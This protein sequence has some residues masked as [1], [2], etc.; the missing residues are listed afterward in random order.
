MI[1]MADGST[2]PIEQVEAGDEVRSA[3]GG[4][5]FAPARVTPR[6]HLAGAGRRRDH[7]RVGPA[8]R[9]HPGHMH[10]AGFRAGTI[11]RLHATCLLWR[12]GAGFRIGSSR[13]P[14]GGAGGMRPGP[15]EWLAAEHADAG[16]VL[17]THESEAEARLGEAV[18]ARRY[19]L[20]TAAVSPRARGSRGGGRRRPGCSPSAAGASTR[21]RRPGGCSSPT[22]G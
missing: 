10:F 11:P 16:W 1:T 9:Q 21:P 12:R 20:P 6:P 15:A 4:G 19:G 14:D 3:Q 5:S 18:L 2:K 8:D 13:L 22:R 7:D 17:Q